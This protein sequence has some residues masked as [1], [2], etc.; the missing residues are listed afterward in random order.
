[1]ECWVCIFP[2]PR[3]APCC[4]GGFDTFLNSVLQVLPFQ[5]KYIFLIYDMPYL[6]ST[7]HL[8]LL[9]AVNLQAGKN[10][11]SGQELEKQTFQS[12]VRKTLIDYL[13]IMIIAV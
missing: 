12:S 13:K 2:R 8:G 7:N 10:V 6:S 1:M 5:T 4:S 3:A 9:Y 11:I